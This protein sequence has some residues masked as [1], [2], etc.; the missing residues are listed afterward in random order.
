MPNEVGKGL[1]DA[2]DDVQRASGNPVF[3]SFS[4]DA[5]GAGRHQILDRDWMV[6]TQNVHPGWKLKDDSEVRFG[7][8]KTSE[9]C[10]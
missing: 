10:P 2:Q 4:D 6:C 9:S 8:V 3:I 5:G 1:Q 7:V